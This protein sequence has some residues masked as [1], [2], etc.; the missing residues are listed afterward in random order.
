MLTNQ[1]YPFL[2]RNNGNSDQFLHIRQSNYADCLLLHQITPSSTQLNHP[3]DNL[4]TPSQTPTN[5]DNNASVIITKIYQHATLAIASTTHATSPF[6]SIQSNDI[7]DLNES[8]D[9]ILVPTKVNI[10]IA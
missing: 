8:P 2:Q 3:S 5:T 4:R 1:Y 9:S 6:H 10:F 7:A